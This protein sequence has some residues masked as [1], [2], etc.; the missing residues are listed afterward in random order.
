MTLMGALLM[1]PSLIV[2]QLLQFETHVKITSLEKD[3]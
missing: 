3:Y 2:L 1:S